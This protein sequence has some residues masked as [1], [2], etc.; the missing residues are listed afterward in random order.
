MRHW[1][2]ARHEDIGALEALIESAYRGEASRAGWTTE[3]DLLDGQRINADMLTQTMSDP[4][5]TMLA[6]EADG[7]IIACVTVE[8][9]DGYGYIATVSVQPRLQG[10]GLGR[11]LLAQAEALIRSRWGLIRA[12]MTVIAQRP[13]LIAWYGRRGYS[14]TGETAPF[15]YGDPRFGAP[16]RD[17]LYFIVLEKTLAA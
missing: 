5:Q 6:C 14:D 17:D 11:A 3:A 16:K 8:R 9:G 13:E 15:P 10:G 4:N 7:A 2:D 12:R 1:R